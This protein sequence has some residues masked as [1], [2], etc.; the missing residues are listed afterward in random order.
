MALLIFGSTFIIQKGSTL[1]NM[2]RFADPLADLS[3]HFQSGPSRLA[4]KYVYRLAF[5]APLALLFIRSL[6]LF[7]A[8]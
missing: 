6:A 5:T 1:G 7:L 8:R 4:L 3:Q 2:Q